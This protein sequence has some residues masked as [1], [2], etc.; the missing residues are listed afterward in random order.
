MKLKE[1]TIEITQKCPN[2]CIHCSSLS[3]LNC[4]TMLQL[5]VI[6]KAID[7]AIDLGVSVISLSGG[8]PFMHPD[9]VEIIKYIHNH[10]ISCYV[11]TSGIYHDGY[12]FQPLSENMLSSVCGCIDKLIFNIEAADSEMYEVIMGVQGGFRLMVASVMKSVRLGFVVECH[13]VVMKINYHKIPQLFAFCEALGISRI[14]FLRLV[15]QGRAIDNRQFTYLTDEE[16]KVAKKLIYEQAKYYSGTIR[17]GMPMSD[18][19]EKV[20]CL[21]GTS[22]L[23]IRYDGNVYPCEAFKNDLPKNLSKNQPEN[24]CEK[25]LK[26][27]Y[28]HSEYLNDIRCCLEKY[29]ESNSCETCMSQ[30]YLT[31]KK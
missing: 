7:D 15:M 25:S 21:A 11:Y 13:T 16:I 24:I 18:C 14:S 27:I 4:S 2:Y 12:H 28:C 29:H 9:I 1:I 6:K 23:D 26:E 31:N 17:M 10:R 19:V 30:Y 22:K 20:N 5:E 8:E 3:S